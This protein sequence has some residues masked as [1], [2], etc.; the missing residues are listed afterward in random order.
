M[1]SLQLGIPIPGREIPGGNPGIPME[2]TGHCNTSKKKT[3]HGIFVTEGKRVQ[4]SMKSA[5]H[6][7]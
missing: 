1:I 6:H 7:F 2:E 4:K 5:W 3:V